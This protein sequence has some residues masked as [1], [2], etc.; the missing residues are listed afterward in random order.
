MFELFLDT[1][2]LRGR[3]RACLTDTYLFREN[4]PAAGLYW[5]TRGTVELR[6]GLAA[7]QRVMAPA[8]L[9]SSHLLDG[10]GRSTARCVGACEV[11]VVSRLD[12]LR[13]YGRYAYLRN[14]LLQCLSQEVRLHQPHYE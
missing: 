13:K 10:L 9:G 12:I 11:Q 6:M 14:Y 8:L 4:V 2:I 1:G 5:L 3:Y 7:G